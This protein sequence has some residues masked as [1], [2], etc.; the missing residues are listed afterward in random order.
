LLLSIIQLVSEAKALINALLN[1]YFQFFTQMH[2]NFTLIFTTV[3]KT[4][5]DC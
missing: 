5:L 4:I 2:W 1:G 3:W